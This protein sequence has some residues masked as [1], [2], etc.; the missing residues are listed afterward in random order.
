MRRGLIVTACGVV[1]ALVGWAA[2][3][4]AVPGS[5]ANFTDMTTPGTN[6][7]VTLPTLPDGTT[8]VMSTVDGNFTGV[9]NANIT[10]TFHTTILRATL[11]GV[12]D[13][14]G[15]DFCTCV[16]DNGNSGQIANHLLGVT[17]GTTHTVNGIGLGGL[18]ND[19]GTFTLVRQGTPA[20]LHDIGFFSTSPDCVTG[21]VHG[22]QKGGADD[23][24][25]FGQGAVV[26][27]PVTVT[28]GGQLF[29]RGATFNGP[30]RVSDASAVAICGTS[31]S[32]PLTITDSTGPTL[33][34]EPASFDCDGNTINGPVRLTNDIVGLDFSGNTV[35]GPVM[36]T[37]NTGG[38]MFGQFAP[39]TIRGP[40]LTGNNK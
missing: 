23:S 8:R 15:V 27:G 10:G 2:V 17:G 16:D 30:V 4:L 29:A 9:L 32:G 3:A 24:L 39:N 26:D 33:V 11:N 7:S 35:G 25:C 37:G 14:S 5:P 6:H 36:A 21:R 18:S 31:I 28:D 38:F 40:I 20:V 22:P 12:S 34:G 1:L 19:R 13:T